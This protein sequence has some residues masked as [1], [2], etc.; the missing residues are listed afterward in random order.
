MT[1]KQL[2]DLH[3]YIQE[4]INAGQLAAAAEVRQLLPG[5]SVDKASRLIHPD[6]T[7]SYL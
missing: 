3:A 6:E 1:A 2:A 7:Q 4:L 5:P